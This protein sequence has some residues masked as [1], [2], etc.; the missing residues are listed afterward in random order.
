M[1]PQGYEALC[2]PAHHG[3]IRANGSKSKCGYRCDVAASIRKFIKPKSCKEEPVI[4]YQKVFHTG[5][6]VP[7]LEAAMAAMGG[8]LGVTWA[9]PWF[10]E[11]MSYWTPAG[12]QSSPLLRVTYSREGPQHVEL[13]Q[14]MPGS[15][16]DSARCHGVHHVGVWVDD[17]KTEA[18]SLAK[19]GWTVEMA[20]VPPDEGY[21][22]FAYM[23]PATGD[24]LLELVSTEIKAL[25]ESRWA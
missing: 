22:R 15:P 14:G 7:N 6:L 1:H 10:Y 4:D 5:I 16:W 23:K 21:G 8:A 20:A 11:P 3:L 13:I 2:G 19:Q 25:M 9:K 24:M 12:K 18:A 17:L